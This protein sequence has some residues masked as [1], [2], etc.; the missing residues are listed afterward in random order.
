MLKWWVYIIIAIFICDVIYRVFYHP[1]IDKNSYS[2][3]FSDTILDSNIYQNI[4]KEEKYQNI[5]YDRVKFDPK[6]MHFYSKDNNKKEKII[7]DDEDDDIVY[8]KDNRKIFDE[9]D[10]EFEGLIPKRQKRINVTIEYDE[11]YQDLYSSLTRQLDGN[12]SYLNFYPKIAKIQGEKKILKYF[13]YF[14]VGVCFICTYTVE[15]IINI[16]CP[17]MNEGLKGIISST[18]YMIFGLFY[19]ILMHLIKKI[20]HSNL[21]EVYVNRK[22]KYSTLIKVDPPTYAILFNILKNIDNN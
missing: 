15:K 5:K 11:Q 21:F 20:S 19:L 7:D 2:S 6:I 4:S 22:L 13:L 3:T 14:L 10:I 16:C 8:P 17:R 1:K 18:K 12:I 9:D